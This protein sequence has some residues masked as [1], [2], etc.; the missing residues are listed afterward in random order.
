MK[1]KVDNKRTQ[2]QNPHEWKFNGLY[3]TKP[4]IGEKANGYHSL[5]CC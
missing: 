4:F 3:I 1:A 2:M 5:L